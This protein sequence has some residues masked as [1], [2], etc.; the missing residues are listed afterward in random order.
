VVGVDEDVKVFALIMGGSAHALILVL[1][2]IFPSLGAF[3]WSPGQAPKRVR[4]DH[5]PKL[6]CSSGFLV[7]LQGPLY[8]LGCMGEYPAETLTFRDEIFKGE[9]S[10]AASHPPNVGCRRV[11]LVFGFP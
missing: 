10:L 11:G 3:T 8:G 1:F 4:I 2:P 5:F 9:M 7:L 6:V